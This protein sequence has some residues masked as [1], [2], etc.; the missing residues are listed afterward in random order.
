LEQALA[1]LWRS[2]RI[3]L[4]LGAGRVRLLDAMT[5]RDPAHRPDCAAITVLPYRLVE[6]GPKTATLVLPV[7]AAETRL[8]VRVRARRRRRLG[9]VTIRCY[10]CHVAVR[11]ALYGSW[12]RDRP[13]LPPRRDGPFPQG[14]TWRRAGKQLDRRQGT[15]AQRTA[16]PAGSAGRTARP[17]A[18]PDRHRPSGGGS[19]AESGAGPASA[20]QAAEVLAGPHVGA[21]SLLPVEAENDLLRRW[22]E[23][24]ISFVEDPQ[25]SVQDADALIH[26]I[27]DALYASFKERRG[28]MAARICAKQA[29]TTT[30]APGTHSICVRCRAG[31]TSAITLVRPVHHVPRPQTAREG[32]VRHPGVVHILIGFPASAIALGKRGRGRPHRC[33]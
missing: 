28:D 10:T 2:P 1:R 4:S 23:I 17:G 20:A 30:D 24:Q 18:P 31:T 8:A 6:P 29:S 16:R 19:R 11:R 15:R 32:G 12:P 3:P 13:G 21:D 9:F 14:P 33:A 27:G 26:D 7:A 5:A 22:T 25:R